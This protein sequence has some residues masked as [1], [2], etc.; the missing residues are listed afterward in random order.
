MFP[1]GYTFVVDL[2]GIE[3]AFDGDDNEVALI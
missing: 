1:D 3:I 2:L